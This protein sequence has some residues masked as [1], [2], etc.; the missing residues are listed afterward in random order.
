MISQFAG[1]LLIA[2]STL[3]VIG[4]AQA[5]ETIRFATEGAF[6]PFNERAPDGS[7]A[8]FEIDLGMALCAKMGRHCEF[9]AQEWDG[10]IPGLLAHKYDGIFASM[11]I[12]EERKRKIDFSNKYYDSGGVFIAPHGV[13]VDVADKGLSGKT[14]GTLAGSTY[15][16]YLEKTYPT[17]KAVT[18]P[19]ADTLYLDLTSGRLDAIFGDAVASDFGLLK[20]DAGKNMVFAS[21]IINDR[22]CFGEGAG[23][24][25]R[26][27]DVQLRADLNKAIVEVRQDG[28][29]DKIEK[30]YFAYDIYGN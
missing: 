1:A 20:T 13:T 8:G 5:G 30:K 3:L 19:N 4:Q 21:K 10:M 9:V 12:T 2:T 7:L 6:P 15:L 18:Y 26:K 17:A 14:V 23:I 28:T 16:C 27:E 24:G 25:L 29:Y 22:A 11:A